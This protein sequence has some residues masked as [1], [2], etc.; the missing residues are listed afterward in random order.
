MNPYDMNHYEE[1]LRATVLSEVKHTVG[2]IECKNQGAYLVGV[3]TTLDKF[4]LKY[5]ALDIMLKNSRAE[6][7]RVE[8]DIKLIADT[9]KKYET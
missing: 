8:K 2:F 1:A 4:I 9:L 5:N 6:T 7:K 3:N